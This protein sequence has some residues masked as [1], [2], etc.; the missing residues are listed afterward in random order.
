MAADIK[1]SLVQIAQAVLNE[2]DQA[3][4]VNFTVQGAPV[5]DTNPLPVI[6][7]S[8][9]IV[10]EVALNKDNDSVTAHQGGGAWAVTNPNI[11]EAV[12]TA[13]RQD[14]SNTKLDAVKASIDLVAAAVED[15]A[16]PSYSTVHVTIDNP[17]TGLATEAKQNNQITELQAIKGYVDGVESTLTSIDTKVAT[18]AKQDSIITELQT[19]K[20]SS[21]RL[22]VLHTVYHDYSVL[23]NNVS[24]AGWT[25]L[26]GGTIPA[27]VAIKSISIFD[28]SGGAV[29]LGIGAAPGGA[30]VII[31]PGGN[32]DVPVLL[33]AGDVLKLRSKAGT[34]TDGLC[35]I[36]FYG[37]TL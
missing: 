31:T 29:E 5:S 1:S 7:D 34:L 30:K 32:G 14:T 20:G 22:D 26:A 9:S 18:A 33:S 19:I 21:Q 12:A 23:A 17:T 37:V 16:D 15:K 35:I 13:A 27:G 36:N 24:V 2:A 3:I 11:T 10:V 28:S 6:I 8:Q 25:T 4:K